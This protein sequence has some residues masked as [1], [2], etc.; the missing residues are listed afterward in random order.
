MRIFS[1]VDLRSSSEFAKSLHRS[2][3]PGKSVLR[4]V[5]NTLSDAPG[6]QRHSPHQHRYDNVNCPSDLV[7]KMPDDPIRLA[8][9]TYPFVNSSAES[10]IHPAE[11]SQTLLIPALF[12]RADG[13]C[14]KQ[15]SPRLCALELFFAIRFILSLCE[16]GSSATSAVDWL[17]FHNEPMSIQ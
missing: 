5:E 9:H 6:Y 16:E 17:Y 3:F 8:C 4:H 11:E 10:D 7:H 1:F 13:S 2:F 14:F 12:P 15:I